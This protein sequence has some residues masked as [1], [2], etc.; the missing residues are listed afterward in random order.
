MA[1]EFYHYCNGPYALVDANYRRIWLNIEDEIC[2][3]KIRKIFLSKLSVFIVDLRCYDNHTMI[4]SGNCLEWTVPHTRN[5]RLRITSVRAVP[6]KHSYVEF[7]SLTHVNYSSGKLIKAPVISVLGDDRILDLQNQIFLY[8]LIISNA[9][10]CNLE[11]HE[12]DNIFLQE[13][14]TTVIKK[15]LM[16]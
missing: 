12:I 2:A 11:M 8:N 5:S 6:T 4:N 3:H 14:D 1:Q 9:I 7:I 16:I 10:S 13:I 15:E